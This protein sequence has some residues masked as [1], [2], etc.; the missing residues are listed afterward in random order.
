MQTL[1]LIFH[2]LAC[3]GIIGL[4]LMQHGKGADMGIAF[5]SGSAKS[6]FGSSGA[7]N[8]MVKCTTFLAIVFFT[9]S[10]I[11]GLFFHPTSIS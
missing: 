9:T 2:T 1:I 4:V 10:L 11:L 8:F 3:L 6:L 7:S 5:G